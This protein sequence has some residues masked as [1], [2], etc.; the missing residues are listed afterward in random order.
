MFLVPSV[1][2]LFHQLLLKFLA[3]LITASYGNPYVLIPAILIVAG[4]VSLRW[5][6]L[7]TSREIKRLEAIGTKGNV[8]HKW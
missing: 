1:T 4:F 8:D 2:T 5:Y 7:K 6:F 3:V